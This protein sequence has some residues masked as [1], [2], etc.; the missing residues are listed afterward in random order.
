VFKYFSGS[1]KENRDCL[2]LIEMMNFSCANPNANKHKQW[3]YRLFKCIST[4]GKHDV[5]TMAYFRILPHVFFEAV[6]KARGCTGCLKKNAT[7]I[8]QAVV[9]HKRG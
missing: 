1:S 4:P 7:E 9:H 2:G 5:W 6:F 3:V 8:K